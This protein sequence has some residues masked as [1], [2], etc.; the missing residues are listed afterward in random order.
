[1]LPRRRLQL[2]RAAGLLPAAF[3]LHVVE[4]APGF[5]G[6]ARRH[7]SERYTRRDFWRNNAA[8]MLLTL[9]TA[10]AISRRLPGRAAFFAFYTLVLTQQALWNTVFHAATTAAWREYSP[11]LVTAG[12]LFLP[13]WAWTTRL[14]FQEDLLS[15]RA[16]AAGVVLGG[17]IHGTAVAQQV[18][19]VGRP[20]Y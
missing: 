14:A 4:E 7:A 8:G 11:G 3:A 20:G 19:F 15:G 1:V 10:G 6:W 5:T 18:F 16:V 17:A 2:Q 13:L 9:P 12:A